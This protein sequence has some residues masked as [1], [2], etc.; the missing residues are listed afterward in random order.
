[1]LTLPSPLAG[2]DQNC[3][4]WQRLWE[5]TAPV[6]EQPIGGI[7]HRHLQQMA[8][9]PA[10]LGSQPRGRKHLYPGLAQ[11]NVFRRT[12]GQPLEVL[13]AQHVQQIIARAPLQTGLHMQRLP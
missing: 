13:V 5:P 12:L 1:M 10:R 6:Q 4:H 3:A 8:A 9:P 2:A 11:H 7:G